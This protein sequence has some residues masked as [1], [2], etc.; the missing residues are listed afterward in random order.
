[1][2]NHVYDTRKM[3]PRWRTQITVNKLHNV[4]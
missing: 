2:N 4:V 3:Y 1:L